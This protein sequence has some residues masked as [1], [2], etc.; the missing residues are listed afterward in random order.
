MQIKVWTGFTKRIDSTKQPTGG[1]SVDVYLKEECTIK[2]PHFI[3]SSPMYN[4]NYVQAF[5]NYYFADVTN[6]DGHRCE[7]SCT[8]DHLATFKSYVSSY[9]GLVEYTSSSSDVTILDPRNK[10]TSILTSTPTTMT[11]SGASFNTVGGYI[12]GVLSESANGTSGVVDYYAMT[13]AQMTAFCQELYTQTLLDKIKDQ[14]T[15][16]MES[17]VSCIWIPMTG[18]GGSSTPIHIGREPMVAVGGRIADRI[19][20]FTTGLTTISFMTGSGG[21]GAAMTYLEKAPYCTGELYLPFVGWVPLDMDLA[22]YYK[23]IQ[24]DGWV[25]IL[26]GDIVYKVKYGGGWVSTFNGNIATKMPVTGASYDGIGV[27]TGAITAI[28]GLITA[29]ATLATGGSAALVTAG[30]ATAAG[31]AMGAA[32]SAE[33]HTMINGGNSSAIGASLGTSPIVVI[34][35]LN[36]SE[37]ALTAYQSEQGM[38]Y[39]KTATLSSLSGYIKCANASVSIPGDGAEQETVNSYLNSGFYLE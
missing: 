16:A 37:T 33:L 21:S 20:S 3:L 18:I 5:G 22:G 15:A 2:S 14:F 30:L 39:F 1:T 7:I 23:S 11:I 4:I 35:Q 26:T 28:G 38:P 36:P 12:L 32:K 29:G 34:H 17:L 31:G 9:T 13:T 6:L 10:P 24:L 19:V 27:A 8:L 25:D